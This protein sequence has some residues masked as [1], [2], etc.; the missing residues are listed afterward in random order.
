MKVEEAGKELT[1]EKLVDVYEGKM[2]IWKV[3]IERCRERD[4]NA[5]I[6]DKE[7]FDRLKANI[8]GTEH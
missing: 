6:M 5:R 1:F 7:T 8:A 2:S 4:K 3:N